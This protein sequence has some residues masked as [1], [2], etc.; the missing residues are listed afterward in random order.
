MGRKKT[1]VIKKS[2][3]EIQNEI[4]DEFSVF[5]G[6]IENILDH[7]ISI[8]SNLE[9]MPPSLKTESAVVYGCQSKVWLT[10]IREGRTVAYV[11]DSESAFTKGLIAIMIRILTRQKYNDIIGADLYFTSKIGLV[12]LLGQQRAL[13]LANIIKHMKMIAVLEKTRPRRGRKPKEKD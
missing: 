8:G 3:S 1:V 7:I 9:A 4:I 10:Y 13:G 12:G 2:I 6:N 5:Q 11:G